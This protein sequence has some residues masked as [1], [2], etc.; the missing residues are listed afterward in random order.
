MHAYQSV[1]LIVLHQPVPCRVVIACN[2]GQNVLQ[3]ICV[4]SV[5]VVINH[6]G[7]K[8]VVKVLQPSSSQAVTIVQVALVVSVLGKHGRVA[9]QSIM[10]CQSEVSMVCMEA[11]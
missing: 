5:S 10:P 9:A 1:C 11:L 2:N 7:V 4:V 3:H 8:L 6:V